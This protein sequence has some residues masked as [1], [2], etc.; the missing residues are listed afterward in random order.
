VNI[1]QHH[2]AQHS[3]RWQAAT[4]DLPEE[5]WGKATIGFCI[6]RSFCL[7]QREAQ[8]VEE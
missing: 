8:A 2:C 6:A 3:P 5:G 1:Q 7:P 4:P